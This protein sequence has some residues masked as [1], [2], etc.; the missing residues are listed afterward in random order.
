MWCQYNYYKKYIGNNKDRPIHNGPI[1]PIH[2]WS[3]RHKKHGKDF[4][5]K[6]HGVMVY[7]VL[8]MWSLANG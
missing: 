8:W 4:V 3:P 1:D 7:L 2:D 5:K 6:N